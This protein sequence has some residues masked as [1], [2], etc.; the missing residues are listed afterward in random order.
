VK[1]N[2]A[3]TCPCGANH[4]ADAHITQPD[5]PA[6]RKSF[7]RRLL[8]RGLAGA[9]LVLP[10]AAARAQ[11]EHA[12]PKG[13]DEPKASESKH[14]EKPAAESKS[15]K[16]DGGHGGWSYE[17][18]EGPENWA[19]LKPENAICRV[20]KR[21]T[22]I[23]LTDLTEA[24]LAPVVADYQ[25]AAI[26]VVDNGH[27]IQAN[28]PAGSVMHMGR[29]TFQLLQFHFHAPSEHTLF[30]QRFDM[31]LHLVHKD[32][33]GNLGVLGALIKK[34]DRNPALQTVWD[35][36]PKGSG[37]ERKGPK[38]NAASLLPADLSYFR[39]SGSLTTP[40]CSE[41]VSWYVLKNPITASDDQ[42]LRFTKLYDNN[43]RPLQKRNDRA[44]IATP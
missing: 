39:Y 24:E 40:P 30:G 15:G 19:D 28:I 32:E 3:D 22:P 35:N 43:S 21:Q 10:W 17:G 4:S 42:I 5:P 23:D 18:A 27:T 13:H 34:G 29:R 26:T 31:E 44:L 9:A 41:G 33:W 2:L 20:G 36:I 8:L 1:T 11:E 12:E 37:S 38:F 7:D 6:A 14:G 25:S 16:R